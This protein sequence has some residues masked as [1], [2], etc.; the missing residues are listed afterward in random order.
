MKK[1]KLNPHKLFL[2]CSKAEV[3]TGVTKNYA[4]SQ[5]YMFTFSS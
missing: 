4:G 1:S 2:A 5:D 3:T